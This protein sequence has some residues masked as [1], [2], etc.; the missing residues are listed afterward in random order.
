MEFWN[1]VF[2]QYDR[3]EAGVLTPLPKP[4]IDTGAGLERVLTRAAGRRLAVGD[5]PDAADHRARP[6]RSP[7]GPTRVGDY[8]DRDS[9]AIRVLAEHARS[10][11]MLVADGVFPSQRGAGLRA[12][13]DHPAR[14]ALR[15]PARH[16]AARA[17]VARRRRH[18]RDG[19]RLPRRRPPARLHRRRAR[20][21]GGELPPDPAQRPD[22]PRARAR[23]TSA[24]RRCRARRRSCSTTP[25]ASRSS[26]PRR[27]PPSARS[28]STS[29]ASRRR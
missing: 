25:T 3:D 2:M 17:A 15:L 29:P 4:S 27:S 20:Q 21:G 1:L 7:G 28:R 13:T 11:S 8:D 19:Q 5:R 12:A 9:F 6:A 23:S 16:R 26:S 18:R 14:R 22:H 10:T 24:A